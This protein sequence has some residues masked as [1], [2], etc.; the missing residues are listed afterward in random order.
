MF[1]CGGAYNTP[2]ILMLSGIGDPAALQKVGIETLHELPGVGR[3]L[4]DHFYLA[5]I[6]NVCRTD[7]SFQPHN[8]KNDWSGRMLAH[9]ESQKDGWGSTNT[10]TFVTALRTTRMKSFQI[11]FVSLC[12]VSTTKQAN[13]SFNLNSGFGT[14]FIQCVLRL[15]AKAL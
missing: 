5:M 6:S 4:Q 8:W 3:N 1:L 14:F 13:D 12:Q 2:Q 9:W 11:Y 10:L 15:R 7:V